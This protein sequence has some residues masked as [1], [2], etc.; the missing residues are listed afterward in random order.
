M[1]GFVR[2]TTNRGVVARP[3]PIQRVME[4]LQAWLGLPHVYIAQPSKYTF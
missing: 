3:I 2:I 4:Q 1:L